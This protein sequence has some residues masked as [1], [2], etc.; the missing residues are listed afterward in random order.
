MLQQLALKPTAE[1][2]S[3]TVAQPPPAETQ[4]PLVHW[5]LQHSLLAP[6]AVVETLHRV[7]ELW[8]EQPEGPPSVESPVQEPQERLQHWLAWVHPIPAAVQND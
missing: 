3:P 5:L 8:H 6:H 7:P 4:L 1:Q 2:V